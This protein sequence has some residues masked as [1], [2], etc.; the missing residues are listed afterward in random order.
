MVH[1]QQETYH[2]KYCILT[3]FS[4]RHY[5]L[6]IWAITPELFKWKT[7]QEKDYQHEILNSWKLN[8][9]YEAYHRIQNMDGFDEE[10]SGAAALFLQAK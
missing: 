9:R 1:E 3:Q 10:D 6:T 2:P 4:Q 7:L 5:N 8:K